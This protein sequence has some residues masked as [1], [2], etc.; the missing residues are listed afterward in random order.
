MYSVHDVAIHVTGCTSWCRKGNGCGCHITSLL[1]LSY[2]AKMC[3][4]TVRDHEAEH[5]VEGVHGVGVTY[6]ESTSSSV[7][8]NGVLGRKLGS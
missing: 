4:E 3:W 2:G 5:L 6:K 1:S 8:R 7:W